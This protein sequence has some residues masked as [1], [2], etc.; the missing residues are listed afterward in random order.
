MTE[1]LMPSILKTQKGVDWIKKF[2]HLYSLAETRI[3]KWADDNN[4]AEMSVLHFGM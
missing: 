1:L 2:R 4:G 3:K